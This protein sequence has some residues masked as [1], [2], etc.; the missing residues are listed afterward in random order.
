MNLKKNMELMI[1]I[2]QDGTIN[3]KEDGQADKKD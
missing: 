3:Y 1:L 2:L